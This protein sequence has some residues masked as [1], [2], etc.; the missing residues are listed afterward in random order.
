MEEEENE[1]EEKSLVVSNS[2]DNAALISSA[3]L[4]LFIFPFRLD[5]YFLFLYF[6]LYFRTIFLPYV[7]NPF[8]LIRK[9]S[10]KLCESNLEAGWENGDGKK[11]KK[12]SLWIISNYLMTQF[13]DVK[14]VFDLYS[15]N[16]LEY[17]TRDSTIQLIFFARNKRLHCSS[18]TI[19]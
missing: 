10:S 12:I 3:L 17:C 13:N 4:E 7:I 16:R 5:F 11:L 9:T 6:V 15:S 1:R 19:M 18:I 14:F 2:I 8:L